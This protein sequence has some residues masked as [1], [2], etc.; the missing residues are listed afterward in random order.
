MA[1][2]SN[3]PLTITAS[4]PVQ[5]L[6]LANEDLWPRKLVELPSGGFLVISW[7]GVWNNER[8][9]LT[10]LDADGLID[11]SFGASGRRVPPNAGGEVISVGDN[12]KILSVTEV[13]R[14]T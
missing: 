5:V 14:R 10:R 11:D 12:G 7:A 8:L 1:V 2:Y 13:V 3:Y 9:L 6:E 4:E